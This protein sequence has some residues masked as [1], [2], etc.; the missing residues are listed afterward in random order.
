[1]EKQ[2]TIEGDEVDHSFKKLE[3]LYTEKVWLNINLQNNF[4]FQM[5]R[6]FSKV[7]SY[8]A[9][10]VFR[11]FLTSLAYCMLHIWSAIQ[12]TPDEELCWNGLKVHLRIPPHVLLPEDEAWDGQTQVLLKNIPLF[13]QSWHDILTRVL[14]NGALDFVLAMSQPPPR[15]SYIEMSNCCSDYIFRQLHSTCHLQLS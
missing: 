7:G 15:W 4:C 14:I 2:P 8:W 12:N 9:A 10:H 6:V 1:M 13:A 5:E 3:Q 11:W